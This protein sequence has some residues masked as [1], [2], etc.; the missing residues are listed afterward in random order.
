MNKDH[1]PYRDAH[2]N[3]YDA[4]SRLRVA[5]RNIEVL[6]RDRALA[7]IQY[8]IQQLQLAQDNLRQA[9]D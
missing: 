3:V 1:R 2:A 6:E 4:L 9:K 8:S 5:K 7:L